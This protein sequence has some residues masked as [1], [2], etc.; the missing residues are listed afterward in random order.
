LR[1]PSF[2]D[3]VAQVIAENVK[4][5]T[6][7]VDRPIKRVE[8]PPGVR[9]SGSTIKGIDQI[10]HRGRRGKNTLSAPNLSQPL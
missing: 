5:P 4:L 1:H 9:T 6:V 8:A 10:K 3:A 2:E 7:D